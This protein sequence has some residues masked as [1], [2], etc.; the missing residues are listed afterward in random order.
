MMRVDRFATYALVMILACAVAYVWLLH[1]TVK[2]HDSEL[3]AVN[4][5]LVDIRSEIK[6]L[7]YRLGTT[8]ALAAAVPPTPASAV[9]SPQAPQ[10]PQAAQAAPEQVK[11]TNCTPEVH[12]TY[13]EE[14]IAVDPQSEP[15]PEPTPETVPAPA[16]KG[17]K[18]VTIV[19]L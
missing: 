6:S 8:D 4:D 19:S 14:I 12:D 16:P 5:D 10:A 15:T 9:Q 1:K 3:D 18:K 17:K 13:I 2:Q 11:A 7:A